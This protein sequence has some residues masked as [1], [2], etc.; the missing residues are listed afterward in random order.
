MRGNPG[1]LGVLAAPVTV[2]I[3]V[4]IVFA[5]S[6]NNGHSASNPP[7]VTF[8]TVPATKLALG[9]I[10][11]SVSTAAVTNSASQSAGA[12]AA[13]AASKDF[14]GRK[15]LEYHYAHCV[16]TQRVPALSQDCWAVSLDPTGLASNPPAGVPTQPFSYLVVLVDPVTD[17]TIESVSGA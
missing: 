14:E 5:L 17:Q 8:S 1:I 3:G 16:D 15:I 13:A 9:G 4:A 10:A 7:A 12:A 2:V 11:L 6:A